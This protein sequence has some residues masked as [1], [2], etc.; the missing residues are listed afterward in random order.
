MMAYYHDSDAMHLMQATQV[1]H[2]E[3][4]ELSFSFDGLLREKCQ[5]EALPQSLLALVL[6]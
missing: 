2:K 1:V 6:F 5:Q 4:F 3:I